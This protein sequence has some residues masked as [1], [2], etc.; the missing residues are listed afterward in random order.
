MTA[1]MRERKGVKAPKVE[2]KTDP[3]IE[4]CGVEGAGDAGHSPVE[5]ETKTNQKKTSRNK[6]SKEGTHNS[7]S[8]SWFS[9]CCSKA[10][11]VFLFLFV[12]PFLNY[13]SLQREVVELQ[14]E[15]ELYDVGWGR[16]MFLSC[17]GKGPPTVVL[18]APTGMNSDVW[19]LVV[20]KLEKHTNVCIYDRAGLGFSERPLN[21]TSQSSESSSQL[22]VNNAYQPSPFTVESMAE[23]LHRLI[24]SS[25]QQPLPLILVGAELGSL[26]AQ[27]YSHIY[28][29][30][31]LGLVLINPL[32]EDLFH[33][34]S[35]V[36]VQHWFG[37]LGPTY[38][39]L[40]L[41]A[42]LGINRLGLLVG[43]LQVPILG[44]DVPENVILRQKYLLCH[45][46]HLSSV[47]DE[48]HF[49]NETFSQMRTVR[50]LRSL[51]SNV[52][53]AV[54]SGNYYDEQ[55]PSHLN[56]AWAI[57]EQKLL[58]KLPPNTQHY[59]VNGADRHMMYRKPEPIVEAVMRIVRKWRRSQP[60][61]AQR[62]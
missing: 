11:Y 23:D 4:N 59:V 37:V 3:P 62:E 44:D 61:Q 55:I 14:P 12:P 35:E 45:P 48:H 6:S 17:H 2:R 7:G 21:Y 29:T 53:V 56:K 33:E 15:G 51:P 9:S 60:G 41:G 22:N 39:S 40:Q 5:S 52:S 58:S 34:A 26:V 57:G 18:D 54:L 27:F 42:A 49:I 16:K 38:Q 46:R 31:I 43:A 20:K 13:S 32:P 24:S 28:E 19:T 1:G 25:S 10:K 36:W 50:K 47:V 8:K 30:D